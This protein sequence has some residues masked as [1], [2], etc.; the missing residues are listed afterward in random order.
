MSFTECIRPF[1]ETLFPPFRKELRQV[2]QGTGSILDVGCG[3]SSPL[4]VMKGQARLVGMDAHPAAI[5]TARANGTHDEFHVGDVLNIRQHFGAKSFETVVAIDLIE[6]LDK[7]D[8][9]RLL[10]TM[11][12]V[13]TR[14]V[15]VFTPNGFVPQGE[16]DKNPWQVHKSGW[17]VGEMQERGY[18]V[19]GIN[20]WKPLRG[21]YAY[22]K[23]HP[24][25]L[26]IAFSDL[27]QLIVRNRPKSAYHLLCIKSL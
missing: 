14:R 1:Y 27:T 23:W 8:G 3:V 19:I 13:A 15:V 9:L 21:E 5:E 17:N 16:L 11:E 6:H 20:G 7:S 2:L 26:W 25:L 12:E 18:E 22:V 24:K 4:A 10:D